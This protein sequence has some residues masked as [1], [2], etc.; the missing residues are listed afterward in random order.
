[1]GN[2]TSDY[3]VRMSQITLGLA[4]SCS[5]FSLITPGLVFIGLTEIFFLCWALLAFSRVSSV[6]K[7]SLQITIV[8]LLAS[9]I[10]WLLAGRLPE[11]SYI[12]RLMNLLIVLLLA[13]YR[14]VETILKVG[15]YFAFGSTAVAI[16]VY[17]FQVDVS[18]VKT[19]RN[20]QF[21]SLPANAGLF[22]ELNYAAMV[23][24][25]FLCGPQS[26]FHRVFPTLF[27]ASFFSFRAG[28]V[29]PILIFANR[30]APLRES[31][32]IWFLGLVV[33]TI[34]LYLLFLSGPTFLEQRYFIWTAAYNGYQAFSIYDLDEMA[35][36]LWAGTQVSIWRPLDNAHSGFIEA[37]FLMGLLYAVV[38]YVVF[39]WGALRIKAEYRALTVFI[40]FL[41]FFMSQSLGGIGPVSLLA[42]FLVSAAFSL[43]SDTALP[44]QTKG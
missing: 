34:L 28:L 38:T 13:R 8:V 25:L 6:S 36:L 22:F 30:Y 14:D 11:W 19:Y 2:Q 35:A 5:M 37:I 40:L 42:T 4:I 23:A 15:F 43:Q 16:M 20:Q 1:M 29:Y 26:R 21:L 12:L 17:C 32:V 41:S 33:V 3:R 27:I 7:T 24:L 18:F 31:R 44:H 10:S 9:F 39:A